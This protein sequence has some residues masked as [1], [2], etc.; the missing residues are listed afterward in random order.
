V[1]HPPDDRRHGPFQVLPLRTFVRNACSSA[2]TSVSS[3]SPLIANDMIE[4]AEV[5]NLSRYAAIDATP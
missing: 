4:P 2:Q 5:A 3:L 1:A